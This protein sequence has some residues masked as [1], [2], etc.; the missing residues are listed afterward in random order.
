[1]SKQLFAAICMA[2]AAVVNAADVP[3][4][5]TSG[6]LKPEINGDV[7]RFRAAPN[8]ASALCLS[9]RPISPAQG[10]RVELEFREDLRQSNG[11]PRLLVLGC[12]SLQLVSSGDSPDKTVKAMLTDTNDPGSYI[13]IPVPVKR[14]PENWHHI[15]C[16]LEPR[17]GVMTFQVDG[18]EV[19]RHP[20][21]FPLP[22][23]SAKLLLGASE[24]NGS[25][26]GYNGLIRNVRITSPYDPPP[27]NGALRKPE[28]KPTVFNGV[29]VRH[30]TI[31]ALPGRHLAFPGVAQLPN[32]DLAV[33]FREGAAHVCPYGRI[34]MTVSRDGGKNWSAP[35]S[36][37][38]TATDERDPSIHALPDGR[39][40]VTHMAWPSWTH[41][42]YNTEAF[43]GPTAY[44][45]QA[46]IRSSSRYMFSADGGRT[47]RS[48]TIGN[49]G[50]FCPH[51]PAYKDGY[52]YQPINTREHGKRQIRMCRISSDAT[53]I[54]RIGLVGETEN[55]DPRLAPVY[56]E[57]HTA[58]LPDGTMVTALRVDCDG[59]MRISFSKDDGK[60]WSEPVRTPIRGFP[61][62]LLPLRDGRLLA[63]YG[64]RY[65]PR[66]V[67]A[68]ISRDGGKTWDIEREMVIRNNGLSGDL[69]YPVSLELGNG[70]VMTV[71]Y[72]ITRERRDCFIEG[73]VYRP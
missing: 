68:C 22:D 42:A 38:D 18:G 43:P 59:F 60:T 70:E 73:A 56:E 71:Y 12:F 33:V 64:Y 24:L 11:Y 17:G 63:T 32:G 46:G 16:T 69:G 48:V 10:V 53:R 21:E 54:E 4:E 44:V 5:W 47:W 19:R 13:Q 29:P 65:S 45:K 57:P 1:M 51:G 27:D 8:D 61:H 20:L 67:R 52:F 39:I 40:L 41:A 37:Y 62:H 72:H 3:L 49:A 55:G 28:I 31:A 35:W 30:F 7:Y 2:A 58:V 66:G 9:K 25:D 23:Q 14:H 36:V 26:R 15:V 50:M 6:R 34:C